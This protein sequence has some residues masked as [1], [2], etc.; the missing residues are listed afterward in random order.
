M[1]VTIRTFVGDT[2]ACFDV[3]HHAATEAATRALAAPSSLIWVD[4]LDPTE[5]SSSPSWRR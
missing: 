2:D 5:A 1:D 3:V 4:V